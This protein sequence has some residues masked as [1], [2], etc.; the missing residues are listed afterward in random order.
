MIKENKA[1]KYML[2]AIGE[3][4]LVVIGILIALQINNWNENKKIAGQG[5]F[6]LEK[7]RFDISLDLKAISTEMEEINNYITELTFCTNTVLGKTD[8]TREEFK[9]N[10]NSLL[11]IALFDQ[12]RTTF[13]NIVSSGQIEYIQNQALTDSITQYYNYD[14]KSWDSALRDYTRNIIAPFML[15]F[16][17]IPQPNVREKEYDD[18]VE[19]DISQSK[20]KPKTVEDYRNEIF[21]LNILRQKIYNLQ[22]QNKE[23]RNLKKYMIQLRNMIDK[24][25]DKT[26]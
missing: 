8:P 25:L 4:I 1:S 10:L 20:I 23:Y 19:I 18:F 26:N 16:D 7:L 24:E 2:Y 15:N 12:N 6:I 3:I 5:K 21:I 13:N 22:G 17:H 9:K 11:T 14:Y